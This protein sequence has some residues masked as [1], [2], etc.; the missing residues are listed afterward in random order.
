MARNYIIGESKSYAGCL[1]NE[2]ADA[3]VDLGALLEEEQNSQAHQNTELSGN[4]HVRPSGIGS[5]QSNFTT[6][7]LEIALQTSILVN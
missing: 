6:S 2:R 4:V 7:S 3:L 5:D 1:L